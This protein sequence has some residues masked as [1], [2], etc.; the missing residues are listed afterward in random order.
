[1]SI[2]DFNAQFAQANE[3]NALMGALSRLS[4]LELDAVTAG[5]IQPQDTWGAWTSNVAAE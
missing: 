3:Q 5:T 1:M 2:Q 4:L